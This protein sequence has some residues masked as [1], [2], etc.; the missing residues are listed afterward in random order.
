MPNYREN[1][2]SWLKFSKENLSR[3]PNR[4]ER[5][6]AFLREYYPGAKPFSVESM[7][8]VRQRLKLE[9]P[10]D[11]LITY[12]N[13]RNWLTKN[14]TPFKD[15]K[16]FCTVFNGVWLQEQRKQAKKEEPDSLFD[17]LGEPA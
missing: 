16:V 14:G 9:I 1:R 11:C 7:E 4:K 12:G 2:P 8:R 17:Y 13:E 3:F 15:V 6:K 10:L 5:Y